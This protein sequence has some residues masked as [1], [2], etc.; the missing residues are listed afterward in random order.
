MR[1]Q[2]TKIYKTKA[3]WIASEV[4]KVEDQIDLQSAIEKTIKKA[5]LTPDSMKS[6][7]EASW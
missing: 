4:S 2:L 7:L 6:L 5:E 3:E 1:D